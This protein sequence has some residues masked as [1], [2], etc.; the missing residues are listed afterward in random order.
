MRQS[1]VFLPILGH[2]D[3]SASTAPKKSQTEVYRQKSHWGTFLR[4]PAHFLLWA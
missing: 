1:V 4:Q 3:Y 2:S